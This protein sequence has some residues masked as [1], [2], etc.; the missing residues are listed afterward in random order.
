MSTKSNQARQTIKH[1]KQAGTLVNAS[2]RLSTKSAV[3][4]DNGTVIA[5]PY[6]VKVLMNAVERS[7]S[8]QASGKRANETVR[9]RVYDAVDEDLENQQE[10]ESMDNLDDDFINSQ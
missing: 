3:F 7:N 4:L 1:E 10:D 5:S 8:K 2:G 9:L 6:S